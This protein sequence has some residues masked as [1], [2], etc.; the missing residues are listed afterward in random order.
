MG[1]IST[2]NT[3]VWLV[4]PTEPRTPHQSEPFVSRTSF[5]LIVF[6]A[7]RKALLSRPADRRF[8]HLNPTNCKEKLAPLFVVSPRATVDV[9]YKQPHG[10]SIQLRRR[11]GSLLL[12][13]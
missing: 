9:F 1:A 13:D 4:E 11:T 7:V 8:A 3:N 6:S 10:A 2:T 12:G 5:L